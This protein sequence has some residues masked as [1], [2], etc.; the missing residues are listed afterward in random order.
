MFLSDNVLCIF[1]WSLRKW[2]VC[3]YTQFRLFGGGFV[4]ALPTRRWDFKTTLRS[5]SGRDVWGLFKWNSFGVVVSGGAEAI[6][7]NLHGSFNRHPID[8]AAD[9][10]MPQEL[11]RQAIFASSSVNGSYLNNPLF[12]FLGRRQYLA[13]CSVPRQWGFRDYYLLLFLVG[14]DWVSWY[15]GHCWPIVPAPDDKWWWLWRKWW[16]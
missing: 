13:L 15:C 9:E 12:T 3:T 8:A 4:M 7:N 5:C 16:N 1:Y 2:F 14:W 11:L 10:R 6:T